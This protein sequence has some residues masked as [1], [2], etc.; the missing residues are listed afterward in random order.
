MDVLVLAKLFSPCQIRNMVLKNRIVLSPMCMFSAEDDGIVTPFH[1]TH[2]SARA[3]GQIG[4]VMVEATAVSRDG[5]ISANDLGIWD[6]SQV[7]GLQKLVHNL[8]LFY[9]Q[10]A[11]QIGHAGGKSNAGGALLAPSAIPFKNGMTT[12]EEMTYDQIQETIQ[13]FADAARRANEAGFDCLEIH[14]AHGYLINQFLTPILNKRTDEYG[15]GL[16]DNHFRFLG[17]VVEAV[18]SEWNKALMV[19]LSMNE[20]TPKG[21]T[22]E[23]M[24]YYCHKLKGL[25][26]DLIDC[27]SGGIVPTPVDEYP[28]YQVQYADAV[29]NKVK[30][31]SGSVGQITSGFQAEDILATDQA[32]LIFVGRELLRNPNWVYWASKEL[33]VL[34]SPPKQYVRAWM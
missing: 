30:M 24:L 20:Y 33:G 1:L 4:L 28:N 23:D 34:L 8:H 27:S 7:P 29:K 31:L 6:D 22:L 9:S 10:A 13:Q 14:G 25:E 16:R 19:R 11:I 18:K 17:Q 12:P 2:Y 3:I 5:R 15:G 21:N 26:V 32:D